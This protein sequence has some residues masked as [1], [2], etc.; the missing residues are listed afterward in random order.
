MRFFLDAFEGVGAGGPADAVDVSVVEVL[1]AGGEPF[2]FPV[3]E[4]ELQ[5]AGEVVQVLAGVVEID[6]LGGFGELAAG[7]VPDLIPVPRLSRGA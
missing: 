2:V 3:Q 7:D 5:E 4:H 1:D 6:D